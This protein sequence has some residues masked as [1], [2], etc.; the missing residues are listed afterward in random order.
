VFLWS[1]FLLLLGLIPLLIAVYLW[2]LRRKRRTVLRYSNL[3][4]VRK[5]L[6]KTNWL[7]Q[8]LPF[9][10]FNI[11]LISL[12]LAMARPVAAVSIPTG[13]STVILTIDVSLS[14]CQSDI[15]PNRLEAAKQAA[16]DFI[17]NQ[18]SSTQIGIVAFAGFA[19]LVQEPTNDQDALRAAL[20][21]LRGAR[22]TAIGSAILK[23][24]DTIAEQYEDVAPVDEEPQL[25]PGLEDQVSGNFAPYVIV[26]LTD[27][28]SNTGPEPLFA[29]EEAAARGVRVY[30]IG[31]G[32][33][34]NHGPIPPCSID[35]DQPDAPFGPGGFG[36]G[37]GGGFRRGIDE[38]TLQQ[39]SSLTGAQYFP[40]E[41]AEQLQEVFE[42][43]PTHPVFRH[44]FTEISALFTGL[45]A[46]FVILALVLSWL[47]KPLF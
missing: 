8:H 2:I 34:G 39:V 26:L 18:E 5:S 16:L 23:A 20:L 46:V 44:E 14:M 3:N 31:F 41:S 21:G 33:A 40:A 45:G 4:L 27:G 24:L 47:W 29:A 37:G 36:F 25:V 19:E 10:I 30:T 7:R 15:K 13:Q 43:L 6:G 28:V 35:V 11:A 17:D 32:T 1:G 42:N 38:A 22:R 9:A 12:V